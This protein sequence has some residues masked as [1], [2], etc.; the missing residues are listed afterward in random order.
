[1]KIGS[2]DPKS[3]A[4]PAPAERKGTAAPAQAPAEASTQVA[5]SASASMMSG[6][7]SDPTFDGAKVERIANAIRNGQFSVNAE[8]IADKLV[9]NAQE[10]LGRKFS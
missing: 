2:L 4:A 1:M 10:L 8:A 5:L 9:A 7:T 3:V 6:M